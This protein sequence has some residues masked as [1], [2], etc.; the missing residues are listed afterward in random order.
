[1]LKVLLCISIVGTQVMRLL[2]SEHR[3]IAFSQKLTCGARI[4]KWTSNTHINSICF[5][6]MTAVRF[7][8]VNLEFYSTGPLWL[9]VNGSTGAKESPKWNCE[10]LGTCHAF[11]FSPGRFRVQFESALGSCLGG[12]K[13]ELWAM[14]VCGRI[15]SFLV[16]SYQM[17]FLTF[18]WLKN[19][20]ISEFPRVSE[21]LF[22]GGQK[23]L[24]HGDIHSFI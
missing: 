2:C 4:W 1:M 9:C 15:W 7:H 22:S 18:F 10:H 20:S 24:S 13:K 3:S 5:L 14:V 8:Q 19:F 23:Y 16:P 6:E 17:L 11:F 21:V 12:G